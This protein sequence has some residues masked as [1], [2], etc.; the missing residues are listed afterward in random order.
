MFRHRHRLT[1]ERVAWHRHAHD[2]RRNRSDMDANA[3]A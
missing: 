2:A 1:E 3:H